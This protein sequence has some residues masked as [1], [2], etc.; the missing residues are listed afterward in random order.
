M[1]HSKVLC[2]EPIE[3]FHRRLVEGQRYLE[4]KIPA[5]DEEYARDH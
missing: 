3:D 2:S 4:R 1:S 5:D